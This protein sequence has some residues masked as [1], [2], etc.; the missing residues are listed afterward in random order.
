MTYSTT[1]TLFSDDVFSD[2]ELRT[3][4]GFLGG[5]SGLTRD[6][7][8]LD[9]RQ[10]A[11]WGMN[12][13]TGVLITAVLLASCGVDP[14]QTAIS[15]AEPTTDTVV[16]EPVESLAGG[17]IDGPVMY[18]A[19]HESDYMAAEIIGRLELD[20]DCLYVASAGNRYPVLWPYGTTWN[21]DSSSVVL[22]GGTTI[23]LGDEVDGG[24][25]YL[26]VGSLALDA[27]VLERAEQCAEEPYFEIAVLQYG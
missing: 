26:H 14:N 24:G 22:P 3:L 1:L 18:T 20:G 25:G 19:R 8:A 5:Y 2:A 11:Q 10:F 6:A 17:G 13:L 27:A 4:A 23:A 21:D 15:T 7:Y 9:L 16:G 12:R